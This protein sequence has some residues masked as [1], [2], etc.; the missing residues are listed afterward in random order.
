ML[1]IHIIV[2]THLLELDRLV[3]GEQDLEWVIEFILGR[4][5]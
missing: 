1:H 3:G 2:S 4:R 5:N